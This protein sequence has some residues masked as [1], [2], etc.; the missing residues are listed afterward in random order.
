MRQRIVAA[1]ALALG[2]AGASVA[3]D[4]VPSA[5]LI[6][7]RV[8]GIAHEVQCGSVRRALDPA[9]PD[10]VHIV[11]R[12][13]L[14]PAM[15]RRKLPDPV[16]L[17]AG[18][19]G[20][21]GSALAPTVMPLFARL[22]NRRDIVFVDQR[23]TG[24]S[25]PLECED[26][27]TLSLAEMAD[28]ERMYAR[29]ER[30]REKLQQLAYGDLRFFTTTLA[31]ADV[32]VV[33]MQLGAERI[34]V[35]GGSYGT[36]AALEYLRQFPQHVRR[37][38][39]DGVAPPDMALPASF[40]TDGQA[41]FEAMLRDCEAAKAC[42]AAHPTLRADWARLLA[43]LPRTVSARHP[44][45]G[46]DE[47]FT[48]TRTGLLQAVRMPLYSPALAAAL[49]QAIHDA[50]QGHYEALL[51]LAGAVSA[52][53]SNALA[54]GM[55]FS[56]VCSEDLPRLAASRDAPGSDFGDEQRKLYERVCASWPRGGVPAAF[57]AIAPSPAPVLLA[58]GGLDPVTPPRHG[59]RVARALGAKALHVVVPNAGHGVMGIGCVRDVMFRFIDAADDAAAL[60]VDAACVKSIPRPAA[61]A[62]VTLERTP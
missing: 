31:M 23:G 21:S 47:A 43:S 20:Q 48:L 56:V 34:N 4:E 28:S 40:S 17:L 22:N 53:R 60:A 44:L 29:L 27:R 42:A 55:H 5:G 54:M 59:E 16:F 38:F 58:S 18:G 15:A 26:E 41:A 1:L 12:Y 24:K 39:I 45:S 37:V 9:R 14:V 51:T 61:F 52:K 33:R 10:G 6:P 62:P 7:C 35:V 8:A 2:M 32:D 46:R 57:Y 13:V 3:Q 50:A 30:C 25:A 36:R 11:V 49:P 19:P